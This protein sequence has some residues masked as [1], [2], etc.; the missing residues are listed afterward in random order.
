MNTHQQTK[1]VSGSKLKDTKIPTIPTPPNQAI[2]TT[3]AKE[4]AKVFIAYGEKYTG[5]ILLPR[6]IINR[7]EKDLKKLKVNTS[8]LQQLDLRPYAYLPHDMASQ[9]HWFMRRF[10][11]SDGWKNF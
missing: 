11:N 3:R 9:A 8:E 1:Q 10:R 4:I 5:D 7:V 2:K 6:D